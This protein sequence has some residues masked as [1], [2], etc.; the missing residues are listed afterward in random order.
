[1]DRFGI[2]NELKGLSSTPRGH[3]LLLSLCNSTQW[4][5][6]EWTQQQPLSPGLLGNQ[7]H[8]TD[9]CEKGPLSSFSFCSYWRLLCG[10]G[11]IILRQ[12]L[13]KRAHFTHKQSPY[14][15]A[16]L[17]VKS[18]ELLLVINWLS[19]RLFRVLE[20]G[21]KGLGISY[22]GSCWGFLFGGFGIF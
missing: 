12:W 5:A 8:R 10:H 21:C 13:E 2:G 16:N 22:I 15:V 19:R 20:F 17:K 3:K 6:N 7:T 14:C 11:T 9:D 1:M 4:S 18:S